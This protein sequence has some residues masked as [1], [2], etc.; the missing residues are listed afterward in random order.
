MHIIQIQFYTLFE[1]SLYERYHPKNHKIGLKLVEFQIVFICSFKSK[2]VFIWSS[3]DHSKDNLKEEKHPIYIV[4]YSIKY[5]ICLTETMD[6]SCLLKHN[7][8][9]IIC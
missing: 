2:T 1:Q 9:Q 3:F 8:F 5:S 6:T 4:S 7:L